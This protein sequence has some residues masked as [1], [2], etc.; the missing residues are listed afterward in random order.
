M[1]SVPISSMRRNWRATLSDHDE[2]ILEKFGGDD[3]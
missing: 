2:E 3:P 1:Q